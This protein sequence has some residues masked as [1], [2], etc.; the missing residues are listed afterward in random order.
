MNNDRLK[1]ITVKVDKR[2][3]IMDKYEI[4]ISFFVV[5]TLGFIAGII[6]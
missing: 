1:G 4:Y 3:K 5:F 2:I 6:A